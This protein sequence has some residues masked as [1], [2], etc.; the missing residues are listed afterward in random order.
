VKT[1][2]RPAFAVWITGLPASG[3][4][5]IASA[6]R[7]QLTARGVDIA[8]LESDALRAILTPH[9]NYSEE[10]RDQFYRQMIYIGMLLVEHGVPVIF[11]ATAN[12]RVYRARARNQIRHFLEVYVDCP[13]STCMDRDPKGIYRQALE[14]ST[15]TVPGLQ[16]VY[17]KPE[18]PDLVIDGKREAPEAAAARLI[19][20]LMDKGYCAIPRSIE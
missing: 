16:E 20:L 11:D 14:G 12:L 15:A 9:P 19:I 18:T 3:K 1:S 13:L 6:V 8:V 4:S 2:R 7:A 17:E 5:T 10:E